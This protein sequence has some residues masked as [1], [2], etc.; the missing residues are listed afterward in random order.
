MIVFIFFAN[1]QGYP[2]GVPFWIHEANTIVS[3][4]LLTNS[5]ARN[6]D[7]LPGQPPQLQK[8]IISISSVTPS[9]TPFLSLIILKSVVPGQ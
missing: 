9:K 1:G 2:M 5:R 4:P 3:A 8:P 7:F 6:T